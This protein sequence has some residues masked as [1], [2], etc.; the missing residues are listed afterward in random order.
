MSRL[1]TLA[2][3]GAGL[4]FAIGLGVSGMTRPDKVLG[5]LDFTGSWDPSLACVMGGALL[6]PHPSHSGAN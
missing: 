3:F 4:V 2:A 5:F 1:R 6:K